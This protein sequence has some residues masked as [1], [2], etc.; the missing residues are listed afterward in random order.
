[1]FNINQKSLYIKIIYY[2]YINKIDFEKIYNQSFL[3]NK[4]ARLL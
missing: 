3:F 4:I 2:N 1:M